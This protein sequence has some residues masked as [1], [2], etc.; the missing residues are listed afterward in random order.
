MMS[1]RLCHFLSPPKFKD[2]LT[3]SFTRTQSE[4]LASLSD[5]GGVTA[6]DQGAVGGKP[7]IKSFPAGGDRCPSHPEA[8]RGRPG[9]ARESSA[10]PPVVPDPASGHRPVSP[11]RQPTRT[12]RA[13]G[14]SP[15]GPS[16]RTALAD[17]RPGLNGTAGDPARSARF[18]VGDATR[19]TARR[20][21]PAP[22]Q[23]PAR[24]SVRGRS[25]PALSRGGW[26]AGQGRAGSS[27]STRPGGPGPEKKRKH[28]LTPTGPFWT[29]GRVFIDRHIPPTSGQEFGRRLISQGTVR[30]QTKK[31]GAGGGLSACRPERRAAVDSDG[32]PACH[33]LLYRTAGY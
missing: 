6:A 14:D 9:P 32:L 12:V 22:A 29:R 17:P 11:G 23:S 16:I 4:D 7:I 28:H 3:V 27:R 18:A 21:S 19:A 13:G 33:L 30:Q 1:G 24:R 20:S 31:L 2:G 8:S 10:R 26:R 15:D 25:W 5:T